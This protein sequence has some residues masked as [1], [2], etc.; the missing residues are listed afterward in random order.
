MIEVVWFKRD[1]RVVDHVPLFEASLRGPVLPLYIIE[2]TLFAGEDYDPCHWTFTS[3]CLRDLR[4]DLAALG[5]P[6]VVRVGEVLD[7]LKQIHA[8]HR[9]SRLWSHEE[10]GNALTYQRD[11]AVGRWVVASGIEWKETPNGGVVRRLRSRNGWA[12]QWEARMASPSGVSSRMISSWPGP[13]GELP[14]TRSIRPGGAS[15]ARK[16][17]LT[18]SHM[19]GLRRSKVSSSFSGMSETASR[20]RRSL[21]LM[22]R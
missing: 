15:S 21:T 11:L 14:I 4:A 3:A 5:Q 12:Q 19:P 17:A 9:I 1:L 18:E 2:P 16:A 7:V 13:V 6:L 10:T 20:R 22:T 8:K